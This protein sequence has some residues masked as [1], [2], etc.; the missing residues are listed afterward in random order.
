MSDKEKV[1]KVIE[2]RKSC[3]STPIM[4]LT[5]IKAQ[6][7]HG[8]LKELEQEKMIRI[9][10]LGK[11]TIYTTPDAPGPHGSAATGKNE[12]QPAATG[13][14][15]T[16]RKKIGRLTDKKT[17]AAA[18]SSP[19]ENGGGHTEPSGGPIAAALAGLVAQRQKIDNAI[20]ALQALEGEG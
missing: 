15:R 17:S 5:G 9:H 11:A 14:K 19:P 13:R 12:Q 20:L 6:Q 16:P 10:R 18:G 7:L 2:Q 3:T 8:I 4:Q 1:L